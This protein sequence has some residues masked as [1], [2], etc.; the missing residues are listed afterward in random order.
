MITKRC[1][2]CRT[3]K[4]LEAFGPRSRS[5]SGRK[6]WCLACHAAR[7]Q[8]RYRRHALASTCVECGREAAV[9]G[10]VLCA[11]CAERRAQKRADRRKAS[12]CACGVPALSGRSS[13]GNCLAALRRRRL[14]QR[15]G[16]E[17]RDY[18][19]MLDGQGG[20]CAICRQSCR[21][22]RRLAVDHDH[23]TG[24]IRGLLCFRC[25]TSLAR[26]EE[27]SVQF[28]EYLAGANIGLPRP[29]GAEAKHVTL[30]R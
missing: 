19:R 10:R 21:T 12:L 20:R 15:R 28:A 13:C 5:P 4:P 9:G 7:Q 26:Y 18:L 16:I 25:N 22:G 3:E 27:Y 1:P 29:C 6:S 30:S 11:P 23:Q 17:E 14:A 8:Q 2:H 24:R